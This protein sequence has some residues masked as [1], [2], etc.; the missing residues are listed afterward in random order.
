MELEIEENQEMETKR[1]KGEGGGEGGKERENWAAAEEK[2]T[3]EEKK[4]KGR[5][6]GFGKIGAKQ[7][8]LSKLIVVLTYFPEA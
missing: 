4:G 5:T 8:I 6:S 7:I 2:L 1:L 3:G